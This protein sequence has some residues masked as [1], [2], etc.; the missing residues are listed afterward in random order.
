MPSF[1]PIEQF[2]PNEPPPR[3][4]TPPVRRGFLLVFGVLGTL[5]AVV[6][7]TPFVAGRVGY[8]YESGR[9]R[10]AMEALAKLDEQGV[11]A[12]TSSLFRLATTAASPAVVHI[13]VYRNVPD[14]VAAT[15]PP[16]LL[17]MRP[18]T[19]RTG[20]GSGVVIDKERGLIVTNNH[21]IEG[22][23]DIG[24]RFGR[25]DEVV[26][27]VV[28]TDPKTDLAV[29]RVPGPLRAEARWGDSNKLDIGDWVLAIGSPFE[30][31]QTVTAGIV[32]ATG[33]SNLRIVGFDSY[34]D[35][36]QT[37]AAINP[38]NSGGPLVNL[39]GE[40]VGINAAILT[41]NGGNQGIGLAISSALARKV[42]EGLVS[43]GRVERGYLGVVIEDLNK[44]RAEDLKVP[45]KE[46]VIIREVEPG[47]PAERAGLKA[48][49]VVVALGDQPVADVDGL[50]HRAASL[51]IGTEVPLSYYRGGE[52]TKIP[53]RIEALP[54]RLQLG[55]QV[56]EVGE[57]LVSR[58]PDHPEH[59]LVTSRITPG[60]AA[61]RAGLVPG[62]VLVRAGE[63]PVHTRSDLDAALATM[64]PKQGVPVQVLGRDGQPLTVTIGGPSATAKR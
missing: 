51:G 16:T 30:L 19:V 14:G 54:I 10:A 4:T 38:G 58:L 41:E 25:G 32:S 29:V 24:I 42:V 13:S 49:D 36:I 17:G 52:L 61:A 39:K 12:K 8:S 48:G 21:V 44:A 18:G 5:A 50:R 37:D 26:A 23:E 43:K 1:D 15:A 7:G 63:R 62:L 11:L 35:F 20:S 47:G 31:D 64:D 28:G 6:Y 27:Q 46:G 2:D 3:P 40:V 53:V 9:A 45:V 34:E 57:P 22:A 55:L 56:E 33:R 59:A 60:S